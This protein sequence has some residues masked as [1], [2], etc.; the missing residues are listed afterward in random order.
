MFYHLNNRYYAEN[1][2][3]V[4]HCRCMNHIIIQQIKTIKYIYMLPSELL[5]DR[6]SHCFYGQYSWKMC[7]TFSLSTTRM[8]F[9]HLHLLYPFIKLQIFTRSAGSCIWIAVNS[10][11]V[12]VSSKRVHTA[13][14]WCI[15]LWDL[16][17]LGYMFI[18]PLWFRLGYFHSVCWMQ[19]RVLLQHMD[20]TCPWCTLLIVHNHS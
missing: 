16:M 18:L 14:R 10:Q 13:T 19:Q 4:Q 11:H 6:M 12:L 17:V 5:Q 15:M 8:I 1:E 9:F 3:E 7:Y 2:K 20:A